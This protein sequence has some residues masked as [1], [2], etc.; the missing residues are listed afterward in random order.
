MVSGEGA[1]AAELAGELSRRGQ[2]VRRGPAGGEREAWES[3]FGEL[4]GKE[5][6]RGVVDVSGVGGDEAGATVEELERRL[7]E[8]GSGVLG[9]LQGMSDAGRRRPRVCGW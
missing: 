1:V 4:D 6:L 3:F 2:E 9:L 8:L 7:R 5:R